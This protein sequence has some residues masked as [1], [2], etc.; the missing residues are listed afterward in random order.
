MNIE[1]AYTFITFGY[2]R[3]IIPTCWFCLLD[4]AYDIASNKIGPSPTQAYLD[5]CLCLA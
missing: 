3:R 4:P 1:I 2:D 5:L